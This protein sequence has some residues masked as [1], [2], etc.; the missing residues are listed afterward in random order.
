VKIWRVKSATEVFP[1]VPVTATAHSGC[2]PAN[3]AAIFAKAARGLSTSISA[4]PWGTRTPLFLPTM[5]ATA[6]RSIASG[7]KL[8]PS[9]FVPGRPAKI[10]PGPTAALAA[11]MPETVIA[12]AP[13][14]G[15]ISAGST[16]LS[17]IIPRLVV[18]QLHR[19]NARPET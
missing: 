1:L 9:T 14:G 17:R 6:P 3:F 5:T 10:A 18:P 4:T 16:S 13:G 7:T 15:A 2:R 8:A 11:V 12:S 19:A